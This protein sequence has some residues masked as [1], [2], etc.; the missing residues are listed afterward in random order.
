MTTSW[1]SAL[2]LL[3]MLGLAAGGSFKTDVIKGGDTK[4]SG[5]K[6]GSKGGGQAGGSKGGAQGKKSKGGGSQEL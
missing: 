2:L 6:G 5:K 1:R 4:G 3:A